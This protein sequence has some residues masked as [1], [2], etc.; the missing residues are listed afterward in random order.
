MGGWRKGYY[1]ENRIIS[2]A[3]VLGSE[4]PSQ[5]LSISQ[6]WGQGQRGAMIRQKFC[7][8]R[9]QR[10]APHLSTMG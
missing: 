6:G 3:A 8:A 7:R 1:A 5:D 2:N 9:Y 4:A 10:A